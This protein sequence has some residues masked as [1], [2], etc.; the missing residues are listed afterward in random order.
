MEWLEINC[1]LEGLTVLIEKY[2][3]QLEMPNLS[4]D[5]HSDISNDLAYTEI[6][7]HKYENERDKMAAM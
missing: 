5:E 4:E 3:T 6:L 7:L 2:R 1:I